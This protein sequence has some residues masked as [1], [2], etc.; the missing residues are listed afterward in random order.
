MRTNL[1]FVVFFAI[2]F[3]RPTILVIQTIYIQITKEIQLRNQSA[4]TIFKST[5]RKIMEVSFVKQKF[6]ELIVLNRVTE[7]SDLG[8]ELIESSWEGESRKWES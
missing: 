6:T 1:N 8:R 3:F 5:D 2:L 4:D 7:T